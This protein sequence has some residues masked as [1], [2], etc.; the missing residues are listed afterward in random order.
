M[1]ATMPAP[2]PSLLLSCL[3]ALSV[4]PDALSARTAIP[5]STRSIAGRPLSSPQ[6]QR[7]R[8]SH[9][10]SLATRRILRRYHEASPSP[11]LRPRSTATRA[12]ESKASSAEEIIAM[13]QKTV[14][15]GAMQ[16]GGPI[17]QHDLILRGTESRNGKITDFRTLLAPDGGF[18]SSRVYASTEDKVEGKTFWGGTVSPG[19][20]DAQ[21]GVLA[22]GSTIA[23][24][25]THDG[26]GNIYKID[27]SGLSREVELDDREALLFQTLIPTGYW[28]LPSI[29]KMFKIRSVG[30]YLLD[31]ASS[32]TEVERIELQ[33]GDGGEVMARMHINKESGLPIRGVMRAFGVSETWEFKD[34]KQVEGLGG[35]QI[36]VTYR[37]TNS[38]GEAEVEIADADVL[39]PQAT[40]QETKDSAKRFTPIEQPLTPTDTFFE[41]EGGGVEVVQT[42]GGHL[43]VPVTIGGADAGMFL[44]DT[45]CG[46]LVLN[47]KTASLLGLSQ[48]GEV[49]ASV[50][51]G[52]VK[53]S[54]ALA[55][56][57][58]IGPMTV[59]NPLFAVMD[60]RG[61]LENYE[62]SGILGYDFFRRTVISGEVPEIFGED[63]RLAL[64]DPQ[65]YY[66]VAP[67]GEDPMQFQEL[68]FL[69]DVPHIKTRLWAAD[70][71]L[72]SR[73]GEELLMLD[74]GAG[75]SSCIFA[76]T[77]VRRLGLGYSLEAG[78]GVSALSGGKVE[79][80][81]FVLGG[82]EMCGQNFERK[83]SR[84]I[85]SEELNLSKR[86]GG[87]VCAKI[88]SGCRF[89]VDYSRK[90][91]GIK[92]KPKTFGDQVKGFLDLLYGSP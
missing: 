79:A 40:D 13:A 39:L 31:D 27:Y 41:G 52:T 44:L 76:D 78:A 49:Y 91:F 9:H 23:T 30:S 46:G 14:F 38:M 10:S 57:M 55:K 58:R 73:V 28:L 8:N 61:L 77:T 71:T 67:P 53:T 74:I 3:T 26:Q 25:Y 68:Q 12:S 50:I 34:Y 62:V 37:V 66:P 20:L 81:N 92:I 54:M 72:R 19:E 11:A 63:A 60:L 56:N 85:N 47:E 36:P 90:R 22:G 17:L 70:D 64:W 43:L 21:G 29:L 51:G 80:D 65:Q 87:A 4:I 83:P 32:N 75:E 35:M 33:L 42:F 88:L 24:N 84:S 6:Q 16:G 48:F 1:A 7:W 15:G 5:R 69:E 86:A 89:V 45:G 59:T 82:L 2:S 18:L